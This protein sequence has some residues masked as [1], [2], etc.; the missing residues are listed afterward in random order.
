M[1]HHHT[2]RLVH[3]LIKKHLEKADVATEE[4]DIDS[5]HDGAEGYYCE[6]RLHSGQ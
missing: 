4:D 3:G 2:N 5:E 1:E 6:D